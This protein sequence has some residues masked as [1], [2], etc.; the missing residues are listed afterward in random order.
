M[1]AGQSENEM[2]DAVLKSTVVAFALAFLPASAVAQGKSERVPDSHKPP[3]GMCRV[4]V[5]GVPAG[6]QPAPTDC[7]TALRNPPANAR[8]IF[9]DR[10]PSDRAAE[11]L[12]P[13]Q[14]RSNGRP[15]SRPEP[16]Q[17]PRRE[18]PRREEPRR[19]EPR[20]TEPPREEPRRDPPK[21]AIER[22]RPEKPAPEPR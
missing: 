13:E 5:N 1:S 4:W 2:L 16:K 18:E 14:W 17:E 21:P 9:G 20:R 19:E 8:V 11:P 3:P 10:R 15:A 7:A 12:L 6:Q 22:R